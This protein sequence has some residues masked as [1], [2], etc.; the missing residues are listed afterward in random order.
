MRVAFRKWALT[1]K[2]HKVVQLDV[3]QYMHTQSGLEDLD[4]EAHLISPG[5]IIN[6]MN[7]MKQEV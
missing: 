3:Q 5:H 4:Q 2:P 1:S 7:P 6:I